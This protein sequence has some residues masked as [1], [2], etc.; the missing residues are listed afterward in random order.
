MPM[1]WEGDWEL[2]S[3]YINQLGGEGGKRSITSISLVETVKPLMLVP[4]DMAGL[5][6]GL[7]GTNS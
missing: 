4:R 5:Y 7:D 1:G 3:G 6:H 2:L